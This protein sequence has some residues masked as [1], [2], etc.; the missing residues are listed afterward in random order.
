MS[1]KISCPLF[2]S[3]LHRYNSL[4]SSHSLFWQRSKQI[5]VEWQRDMIKMLDR[6][7]CGIN[8]IKLKTV[9]KFQNGTCCILNYLG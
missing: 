6:D 8:L 3:A 7:M 4:D 2:S 1:T 5:E 9:L